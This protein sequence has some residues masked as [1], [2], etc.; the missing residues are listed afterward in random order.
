M[1]ASEAAKIIVDQAT[2]ISS[3]N[4]AQTVTTQQTNGQ[5]TFETKVEVEKE[6][7]IDVLL[8]KDQAL[9][10]T[11]QN[12]VDS[13]TSGTQQ[14]TLSIA[15]KKYETK[16]TT[17]ELSQQVTVL[18]QQMTELSVVDA[19]AKKIVASSKTTNSSQSERSLA[20]A[21]C[22]QTFGN[23]T[24]MSTMQDAVQNSIGTM[25]NEQEQV[26]IDRASKKI[27]TASIINSAGA[28]FNTT[29]SRAIN[30]IDPM[31]QL[32]I[33]KTLND[34]ILNVSSLSSLNK[35]LSS[36]PLGKLLKPTI[37]DVISA[38][39]LHA[40]GLISDSTFMKTF[41]EKQQ[42]VLQQETIFNNFVL[43][44]KQD[45]IKFK[46][47]IEK[48]KQEQYAVAKAYANRII[49]TIQDAVMSN[50]KNMISNWT[51]KKLT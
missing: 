48:W 25:I 51:K 9:G 50:V 5:N 31:T 3:S 46:E 1:A 35:S 38:A 11:I 13:I 33:L 18:S 41:A 17:A 27:D 16:A 43:K 49:S 37:N 10:M 22:K 29:T 39:T 20:A 32:N 28:K 34:K 23:Q 24:F 40:D 7:T 19:I 15:T 8:K 30:K 21:Y 14:T 44:A 2:Y 26:Y 45:E 47:T 12:T 36:T 6:K 4:V 42:L